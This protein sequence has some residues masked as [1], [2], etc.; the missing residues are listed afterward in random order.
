MV[1]QSNESSF[2]IQKKNNILIAK[3]VEF[4]NK[5]KQKLIKQ[6]ITRE[7]INKTQIWSF[8]KANYL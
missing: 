2:F 4:N 5:Y 6:K 7:E 8:E 1:A 3:K